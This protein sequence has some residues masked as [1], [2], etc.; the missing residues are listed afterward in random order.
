MMFRVALAQ[1]SPVPGDIE[2]NLT[3]H[4]LA[5]A[6]AQTAGADLLIF[7]ELIGQRRGTNW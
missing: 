6:S 2:R 1:L 7:P 5:I 3:L 4:E